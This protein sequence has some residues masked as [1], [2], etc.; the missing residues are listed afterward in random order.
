MIDISYVDIL[1]VREIFVRD[2][3]CR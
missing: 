3:G 2:V 1:H